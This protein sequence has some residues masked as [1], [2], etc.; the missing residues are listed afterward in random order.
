M[1]YVIDN[2]ANRVVAMFDVSTLGSAV[3]YDARGDIVAKLQPGQ[4]A[5]YLLHDGDRWRPPTPRRAPWRVLLQAMPCE[6]RRARARP[7]FRRIGCMS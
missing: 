3:V 4:I 6:E 7:T 2:P 5:R 1:R